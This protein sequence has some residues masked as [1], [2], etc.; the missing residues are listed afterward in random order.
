MSN[1][2]WWNELTHGGILISTPVLN[3]LFTEKKVEDNYWKYKRLR[4]H[5][6]TYHSKKSSKTTGTHPVH[7]WITN[8]FEDFLGHDP[9]AW[10][11]G[12]DIPQTYSI[13]SNTGLILKPTRV[14]MQDGSPILLLMRDQSP[15]LG[16]HKGR[17]SYAQFLELL[18]K[19]NTQL[20]ILTNGDQIRLVYAGLDHDA[21]V[22]W[23]VDA[24]FDEGESR[25][26]L[27]GLLTLLSPEVL[28]Q[29]D[30]SFPLLKAVNESRSRQADLAEVLGDQI[31]QAVE[32]L[33]TAVGKAQQQDQYFL[34]T[35]QITPGSEMILSDKDTL[36]ALYQAATRLVM[37]MVILFY[38]EAKELLP[39]DDPFFHDNYSIEG[40]FNQLNEAVQHSGEDRLAQRYSAWN[41][42]L[43]LC[44]L[45][46]HGSEHKALPVMAYGGMLFRPGDVENIDPVIRAIALYNDPKVRISDLEVYKILRLL[47]IGKTKV[48]R[49]R[50]TTWVSGPVDF[51]DLRTEYIGM[52]YEGLLDYELK[53]VENNNPL[54]ILNI[55]NQPILPLKLLEPMDGKAIKNLFEKMKVDKESGST[56]SEENELSS[57]VESA[58]LDDATYYGRSIRWAMN[59]VEAARLIR[60]PSAGAVAQQ[61]YEEKKREKASSLIIKVLE[62]GEFYLVR[63]GGTRKGSGTFYTKPSLAV[64]TTQRTLKPLVYEGSDGDLKVKLPRDIL[65]LR[66]CD[67]AV[68]SGTF[69]VAALRYLT[70]VLYES[71]LTHILT[72]RD[73]NNAIDVPDIIP[74]SH[75]LDIDPPPL[76]PTDDGWEEQIKARLK[77]VVV[78]HCLFGV[79]FNGTAV[80]LTRLSLWLET[81]DKD[82]PFE[83]LDHRI[84]H[85]NSLVGT[86]FSQYQNYP[87]KA[88]ERQDGTGSDKR[89]KMI[90]KEIVNPDLVKLISKPGQY[91][92]MEEAEPPQTTLDR[93]MQHWQ[94]LEQTKLFDTEKREEIYKKNI[95]QDADYQQ[96]KHFFDRWCAVWFWPS[97]DESLPT[98]T[99]TNQFSAETRI[100]EIVQDLE[101]QLLFFHWEL[102][103]PE[104]FTRWRDKDQAT[105]FDA[106]LGNPPWDIQKPNSQ[107]FFSNFD[108]IYRTYGKQ[109]ALKKQK[110]M[111][112]ESAD[113]RKQWIAYSGFFKSMSNYVRNVSDPYDVSLARGRTNDH[114]K[115]SWK[116]NRDKQPVQHCRKS[117]Y[118][119]QGG[120]DLNLYKLFLEQS[121][122]LLR[123]NGRLGMIIPSGVYTDKGSTELRKTFIEGCDW[124][125]LYSFE[126]KKKIF[127][128]HRSYKFGPILLTKGGHTEEISC[129]FMR[130]DVEDWESESPPSID[131]PIENVKKFSPQTLSFLELKSNLDLQICEKIYSDRP[132]LGDQVDGGWNVKFAREFDMTNDSHLFTSRRKLEQMGL[133]GP[134]DDA[135]DPRVR[136][137][138]WKEGFLPLFEGKHI[139]QYNP[140]FSQPEMFISIEKYLTKRD[141]YLKAT[142]WF[143]YR[144]V[145]AD[146]NVR[147]AIFTTF[148]NNFVVTDRGPGGKIDGKPDEVYQFIGINNSFLFDYL[149]RFRLTGHLKHFTMYQM[150]KIVEEIV[151]LSERVRMLESSSNEQ[152]R[153]RTIIE[154]DLLVFNH[155]GL[156]NTE[157]E[158]VLSTFPSVDKTLPKIQRQTHI[159]N[160]A[161]NWFMKNGIDKL[162][163]NGW[164]FPEWVIHQNRLCSDIWSP[165]IGWKS[166]WNY[167]KE[168]VSA[169]EWAEFSG[170]RSSSIVKEPLEKYRGNLQGD[171]F[172]EKG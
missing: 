166:A 45:V 103:F 131:V 97:E 32:I 118:C 56:E 85:G 20:G 16:M 68:G 170:E 24:W 72:H 98:I 5:Y 128:I 129:A 34:D 140:Y 93:Q 70:D 64:P 13:V 91:S 74:L 53:S 142:G 127:D 158:H 135:R 134:K 15:R 3:E 4:D 63:W 10:L 55:G 122:H 7:Q 171:M 27:D 42:Y 159:T 12:R 48:K 44:R 102:E 75:D 151:G 49:G 101:S 143:L 108:P 167:A 52:M 11:K 33:T 113:I 148:E 29:E 40:L 110:Q 78:E 41:R 150:P 50:S 90:L 119:I 31:R 160:H 60:R 14:L 144:D 133:L 86:W 109:E 28:V 43:A 161:F 165:N 35:L 51:S 22:Q 146:T 94:E 117:P 95:E 25:H 153:L 145:T 137:R 38:A 36:N 59:A 100:T 125:W 169:E 71:V 126:N 157:V 82:L 116:F 84:K 19:N 96:L 163:R 139:W 62:P 168:L 46:Y 18:R 115:Q 138:L 66:I 30:G 120:A 155:F 83:F 99:P 112:E 79:D 81:M 2:N 132:L 141:D 39:R 123:N 152:E 87:A 9:N 111:F 105:G 76:K 8:V 106:I 58:A 73:E 130:H 65:K 37:R 92:L 156:T 6:N 77:R 26:Q 69:L 124:E 21:W 136:I 107:E 164:E 154:M 149:Y 121:L 147:T 23:Q 17:R 162:T 89:N 172:D 114:L 88:W 67:P 47:K 54:V 104:I 61:Q 80:E 1:F 57:D